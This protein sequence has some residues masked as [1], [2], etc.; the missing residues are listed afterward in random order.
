[1][2]NKMLRKLTLLIICVCFFFAY[3]SIAQ[4]ISSQIG[5]ADSLSQ[6]GLY[7]DAAT[8]YEK[9]A[10]DEFNISELSTSKI[11][12]L[13]HLA[14]VSYYY[15]TKFDKAADNFEK[16]LSFSKE[17][18]NE[19][20]MAL[21]LNNLGMV[22]NAWQQ[23][24]KAIEYYQQSL[25][26]LQNLNNNNE[27]AT[28]L[29]NIGIIYNAQN[30]QTKAIEYFLQA[31]DIDKEL[32]IPKNIAIDL[33][34]IGTTYKA[35]GQYE[36]AIAYFKQGV[37]IY[38]TLD[39]NDELLNL[40]NNL[41]LTYLEAGKYDSALVYIQKSSEIDK[42]S[43]NTKNKVQLFIATGDIY[44]KTNQFT[45]AIEYYTQALELSI[46]QKEEKNIIVSWKSL[47]NVY[48]A[49]AEYSKA[50]EYYTLALDNEIKSQNYSDATKTYNKIGDIYMVNNN[51][52][53]ALAFYQKAYQTAILT[54][55]SDCIA[56]SSNNIGK[57]YTT[58]GQYDK[59]IEF[60]KT[61]LSDAQKTNN[62]ND[63]A[64][65]FNNIGLIY[66]AW[67]KYNEA[68]DYFN[69]ALEINLIINQ[70]DKIAIRNNNLGLC[71]Q[72]KAELNKALDYFNKAMTYAQQSNN[73]NLIAIGFTNIGCYYKNMGDADKALENFKQA[74]D[75][76]VKIGKEDN[77]ASDYNNVGTIYMTKNDF[78]NAQQCFNKALTIDS[79]INKEADMAIDYNNLGAAYIGLNQF[80]Q[81]IDCL[82]KA[83]NIKE[84]L[85]KTATG[86]IRREY[87]ESQINTYNDLIFAYLSI[88][89]I[90]N[91]FKTIELS[92]AKL[93]AERISKN[94][95]SIT[96]SSLEDI[97]STLDE[98]TA[99]IV[100]AT[101]NREDLTM[102][103][104][105]KTKVVVKKNN[106]KSFLENVLKSFDVEIKSY[107][108]D[109]LPENIKSNQLLL[110]AEMKSRKQEMESVIQYYR[111]LLFLP[112]PDKATKEK[113]SLMAKMLF[114]YLVSPIEPSLSNISTLIIEPDGILGFLPFE[115]LINKQNKYF[116]QSIDVSYTQ[117]LSILN[118]IKKRS[119]SPNRKTLL[120]LGGAIYNKENYA[121]DM[122]ISDLILKTDSLNFN[123]SKGT[124]AKYLNDEQIE[125]L[126]K[127]T[128]E[129]I[130]NKA[131]LKS[132]YNEL[133][134]A[135]WANLPGSLAEV[136]VLSKI[137]ADCD[138]LTAKEINEKNIKELSNTGKLMD[139]KILH[140]STHGIGIPEIPELSA[141]ILNPDDNTTED[142]F[143]RMGEISELKL[144]ADFVNLSACETGLGKIYSGEGVVGLS[145]A[146]IV[147]GANGIS[148]SLWQVNDK[149]TAQFMIDVFT[150][151]KKENITYMQAINKTKRLF[152]EGKHSNKWGTPY[153]WAP[154]I[155]Y[156][157]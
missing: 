155:Y 70:L 18:E 29:N 105:T 89:D 2:K 136:R 1:M 93:L 150:L 39:G 139:Y 91:A 24:D 85:R 53:E 81:A 82:L 79:K 117:S 73:E 66:K 146:F 72:R 67:G 104:I 61:A 6:I 10:N 111:K 8:L 26:I 130:I 108:Y 23:T 33:N 110:N 137:I 46:K 71:Y 112:N 134:Y 119:Y 124:M 154:F 40:L 118:M 143:L 83:V 58:W 147:A 102:M 103:V 113:T 120:A 77:I 47:G 63:I 84:K 11:S 98:K 9:L 140:F 21:T 125:Y 92:K 96:I 57:V 151:V 15:A 38:Q 114:E 115:T 132:I 27:I 144:N 48:F 50:I 25:K 43:G 133:G 88:Q 35:S 97:Q 80:A 157:N 152:I 14:G 74:M 5:K 78:D 123:V 19:N 45:Q 44:L 99:V 28:V 32:N 68:I 131:S 122:K 128:S 31:L 51:F 148:A 49:V 13:H 135:Y 7:L 17:Q 36:N 76:D 94:D 95:S 109:Q 138:T 126:Q 4:D 65:S 141:I 87:F 52:N 145:Q 75:I 156:G 12:E 34:N 30:N 153:Y 106:K 142:G 41:A 116:V 69:K 37:D 100:Y 129:A 20:D 16:V 54:K 55:N 149:S 62:Q 22:Y 121:S 127:K 64:E 107:I 56:A 86:D 90:P 60:Y 101:T 42:L 3:N 59:A